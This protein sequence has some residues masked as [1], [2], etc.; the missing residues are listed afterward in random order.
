MKNI[1]LVF[2]IF[3]FLEFFSP[4]KLNGQKSELSSDFHN[5]RRQQLREKLPNNSVAVF[6]SSP[7]RNRA[8]D[9]DFEY[10]P[11]PNFYYLTGWNEPHAV[12]L[13]FS[14]P[15]KDEQ[16]SYFEKLYV[17]ERDARNE[18][19]NGRR[20]GVAG[21]LTMGFDRV[22]LKELFLTDKHDFNRFDTVFM[23][24]F[25]NDV[26]DGSD[27]SD[28]FNLQKHF[29]QA[30]N[31]PENFDPER[32]RLYQRIRQ[33]K[34]SEV[35]TIK[36][37]IEYYAKSD[38]SLMEDP[39]IQDFI[40][41]AEDETTLTD[42]KTRTA[43]LVRDYNFDVDQL[44][45]F[46]AS[47]RE[48]KTSEELTLLKKAVQIS[49][50]GQREVMKAIKPDMTEREVQGIH[51]LVYKKYGAAHE[52]YPSIVGAGENACVLHYITNNKTDIKNQLILMDL[53]A[54]YNGY[55][56][57]VTRTIPV[58]GKFTPEQRALYQIVYDSQTAGINI[59][60]KGASFR[61]I[62]Q[63][64]YT[65]V[66]EGLLELGIIEYPEEFQKYLPHGVAHHIGLDVHDPGLYENLETNMVITVE[67]GI[68]IPEDSPCDPK[69]WNIGIRIEDDILIT[70]AGPINLSADAPRAWEDIEALMKEK[71]ALD[72][73]N[74]P[75]LKVN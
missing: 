49:A 36:R 8:N 35:P 15:Q 66:Q 30:I 23:F 19:W 24:D 69:W 45:T 27:S 17:R 44:G 72:D 67:P 62:T 16:G 53:G 22:V 61:E 41:Q 50:Q 26:R 34:V 12:L 21:A 20:L 1:I 63:A 37:M 54:E 47:L 48:I 25:K 13:L 70:D 9:V 51:Q 18:M 3:A 5:E 68:Y 55:T 31:F 28:L 43:F 73:F 52:G 7:V 32:Y 58:S 57:D 60:Q 56:A 42:L 10:H 65:V 39:V 71:S 11:D 6:F 29:K 38:P 64:C 14:T 75:P 74:L 59:A 4:Q 46:M 33:A 2:S 40:S